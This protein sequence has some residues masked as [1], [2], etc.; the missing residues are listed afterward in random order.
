MLRKENGIKWNS[1]AKPSFSYIKQALTKA[2]VLIS[3]EFSKDFLVFSFESEH[4]IACVLLQK[5]EQ[6]VE[7]PISFFSRDLRDS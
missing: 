6:K 1:E 2:H 5:N 3:R 7:Q 4:T